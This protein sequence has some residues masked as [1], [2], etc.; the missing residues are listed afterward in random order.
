MAMQPSAS[1]LALP[2]TSFTLLQIAPTGLGGA[3]G[4]AVP[5]LPRIGT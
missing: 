1:L 3:V 5:L 4:G 2:K